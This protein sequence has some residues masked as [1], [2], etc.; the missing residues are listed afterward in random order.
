L[1][2]LLIED[3]ELLGEGLVTAL[4]QDGYAVDWL[5]S[6]L[7]CSN[8]PFSENFD[9]II[10][11]LGLPGIDG[12]TLL[13]DWRSRKL[14]TPVLI[15]TARDSLESRV[16]GLD[17]G[18][19]DFMNKPFER[20]E[21]MARLRSLLRRS[22]QAEQSDSKIY[23]GDIVLDTSSHTVTYK[24]LPVN[25]SR[26]EFSLL[27]SLLERPGKVFTRDQLQQ[28]LYS[29]DETTAS[30]TLEVYIH[31]LRKKLFPELIRTIRGIGYVCS[32]IEKPE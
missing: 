13:R 18:A 19:D 32:Q 26:M 8:V 31:S 5:R 24:N 3:N 1:R 20:A 10:L 21:L 12:M 23:Y 6:G 27:H 28:A 4:K 9:L 14:L 30:N 7:H 22:H 29:W 2:I 16:D 25:I 15:L 11:D 17:S